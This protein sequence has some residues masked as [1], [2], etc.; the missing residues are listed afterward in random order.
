M[1]GIQRA[2]G[3]VWV[4]STLLIAVMVAAGV[5]VEVRLYYSNA[6][7]LLSSLGAGIICLMVMEVF[8]PDSPLRSAWRLIGAGLIAWGVGAAIFAGYPLLHNGED[9]PYPYYADIG[10]LLTSPL[11]AMGLWAF[12]KGTGLTAPIWGKVLALVVLLISG[13]W[14]YYAN[15]EG[16]SGQGTAMTVSSICYM[17]F[18]PILMAVTVLTATSFSGGIVGQTWWKVV[19]GVALY[20]FANQAFTYLNLIDDYTTGSWID[21]GWM[22]GFGLIAWAAMTAR[23]MML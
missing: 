6:L 14:G 16:L 19:F 3:V 21:M 17:M 8:P 23:R 4:L 1:T 13:Y 18:D 12:K 11:I 10:Y 15:R 7:Q 5:D 22:L 2:I 20:F 9:T